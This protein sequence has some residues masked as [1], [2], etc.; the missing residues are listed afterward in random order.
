MDK[1]IIHENKREVMKFSNFRE[2]AAVI[3]LEEERGLG[4]FTL[5][6]PS[7]NIKTEKGTESEVG[8]AFVEAFDK[9]FDRIKMKSKQ[10]RENELFGLG[11]KKGKRDDMFSEVYV[12]RHIPEDKYDSTFKYGLAVDF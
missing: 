11:F 1:P 3:L 6:S 7:L 4:W 5:Y 8:Q 10:E 2:S 12:G 9:F